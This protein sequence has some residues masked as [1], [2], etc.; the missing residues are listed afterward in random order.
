MSTRA[1][2]SLGALR[3]LS[4]QYDTIYPGGARRQTTIRASSTVDGRARPTSS[5]EARRV[6]RLTVS[7]EPRATLFLDGTEVGVTP[8][9]DL[10][11]TV[12]HTYLLRIQRDGYR[13]KRETITV[14]GTAPIRRRFVLRRE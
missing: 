2:T 6:A 1:M 8:I 11:L 10:P 7:S 4:S 12:G 5:R 13:T 9:G 14:R 3:G